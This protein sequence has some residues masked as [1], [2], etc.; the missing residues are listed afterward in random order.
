MA[1]ETSIARPQMVR[2]FLPKNNKQGLGELLYHKVFA[3]ALEYAGKVTG[4]FLEWPNDEINKFL[5]SETF[6]AGKIHEALT[7]RRM[8]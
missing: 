2:L 6:L 1:P 7:W 4:M 5:Q 3:A 8:K